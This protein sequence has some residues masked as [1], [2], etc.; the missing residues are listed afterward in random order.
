MDANQTQ[1]DAKQDRQQLNQLSHEVIG[2]ALRV[3][4]E[5]GFGFV[6]KVYENALLV[7]LCGQGRIVE[8]Q[9]GVHVYYHGEI[10]GDYVPDL[11]VEQSL[12]VEIK[13]VARLGL[14]HRQQCLNYLRATNLSLALLLNFG[15]N[16]LEIG[17]VVHAF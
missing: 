9:R 7:E 5:L 8:Q 4:S 12:I 10:I 2:A 1:R 17:R 14:V 11:L 16:R 15:P 6:E 13:T 3:R